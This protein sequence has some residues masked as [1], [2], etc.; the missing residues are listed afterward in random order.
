MGSRGILAPDCNPSPF[1]DPLGG[2]GALLSMSSRPFLGGRQA[3]K[4]MPV[5]EIRVIKHYWCSSPGETISVGPMIT[6]GH[7]TL[8][9]L[10]QSYG[11]VSQLLLTSLS[12]QPLHP[13]K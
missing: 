8:A 5:L 4:F 1:Y 13:A 11:L 6:T 9:S 3:G 7:I 10:L 12:A 2:H